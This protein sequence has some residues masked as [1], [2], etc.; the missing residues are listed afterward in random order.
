MVPE[1]V[2]TYQDVIEQPV[3]FMTDTDKN[4]GFSFI[5]F[6]HRYVYQIHCG[7]FLLSYLFYNGEKT[8]KAE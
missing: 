2:N 1:F 4:C 6:I 7:V 5:S 3:F 8:G